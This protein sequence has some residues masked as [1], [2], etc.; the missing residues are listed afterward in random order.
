MT[1]PADL[2]RPDTSQT[3]HLIHLID[4]A[5]H[6]QWLAGR[7][8]R[9]RAALVA[10]NYQP[11]AY[12][13]AILPGEKP[14]AWSVV[15]YVA[16]VDSLSSWCLAKLPGVLPAGTY[17]L[18]DRE[19]GPAIFGWMTAQYRFERY[20]AKPAAKGPCVLL[21]SQPGA[22]DGS[23]AQARATALVRDMV[24][25]PTAEMGPD[26]IEAQARAVADRHGAT[27]T[28]TRGDALESGY[29][30]IHAV[31]RAADRANAPRLIELVWGREEHPHVALVG[32]GIT[33]DTGGLD[34]KPA[35]GMRLMKKDMGGAAHA[36][37]LAD[38]VMGAGLPVRLHLLLP[39]AENA[40]AGNAF[41]PGDVLR[42]RKG[43]TVEI[44][45]TDAEGRLVLGDALTRAGEDK[46]E[47]I[48]DFA[49]LT[50]A[51]RVA[52]GPDLPALFTNDD[53]LAATLA[54]CGSDVDDPLWRLPLWAPYNDLFKSDI[55]DLSNSGETPFAGASTAALF[56]QRFV[57]DKTPWVHFDTFAWRPTA[58]PGRPKGGE[59]LGLRATFAMLQK[60]YGQSGD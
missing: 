33:F 7:T 55:A 30:M 39:V 12:A 18:A 52:L 19:P 13:H 41:R 50:G 24:N 4:A 15:T 56:L 26:E 14:D 48:I 11:K 43:L 45:N 34:I 59:A 44:G 16:N 35:S 8:E 49:T 1:D 5:S 47:L 27:M 25:T 32:K 23:A 2:V 54:S 51:A 22:I 40:I 42:S 31:G 38:L 28:V 29:P 20:K 17:R 9:E 58:K 57:P 37:A 53:A 36:L 21:S 60:R 6:E 46:P 3:A 10:Q